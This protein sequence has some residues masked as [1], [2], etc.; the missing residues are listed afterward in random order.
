MLLHLNT[1]SVLPDIV[2][3][4]TDPNATGPPPEMQ[5]LHPFLESFFPVVYG[6][7]AIQ[8]FHVIYTLIR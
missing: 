6:I 8:L 5:L 2:T 4:F 3:Y 7:L 1:H